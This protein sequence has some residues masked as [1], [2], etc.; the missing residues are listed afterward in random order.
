MNRREFGKS[1]AAAVAVLTLPKIALTKPPIN[2]DWFGQHLSQFDDNDALISTAQ[3]AYGTLWYGNVK[4]DFIMAPYRV[5]GRVWDAIMPRQRVHVKCSR[6][7]QN[8]AF[9]FCGAVWFGNDALTD[10]IVLINERFRENKFNGWYRASKM[11]LEDPF[12]DEC[13]ERM[14]RS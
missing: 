2:H 12:G 3:R 11:I 6:S 14:L 7:R 10:E 5:T 1:I 9:I 13:F 8:R 4:P